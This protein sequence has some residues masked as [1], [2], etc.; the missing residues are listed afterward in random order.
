MKTHLL[1]A[2]FSDG[3][4]L[5]RHTNRAYT[6]AWKIVVPYFPYTG[7]GYSDEWKLWTFA[8]FSL[9]ESGAVRAALSRVPHQHRSRWSKPTTQERDRIAKLQALYQ[10]HGW[11]EIAEVQQP[12]GRYLDPATVNAD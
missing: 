1:T 3:T 7:T 2:H 11:H 5:K 4:M 6:H 8:G 10:E 9:S 12:E